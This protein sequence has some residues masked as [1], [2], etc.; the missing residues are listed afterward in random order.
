M[1]ASISAGRSMP[2]PRA[3]GAAEMLQATGGACAHRTDRRETR[4]RLADAFARL[5]LEGRRM[6]LAAPAARPRRTRAAEAML[7]SL[8]LPSW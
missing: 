6:S 1:R 4:R 3:P 2:R 7:N 8:P 5:R